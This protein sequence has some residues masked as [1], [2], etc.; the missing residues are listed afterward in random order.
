M[1]DNPQGDDTFADLFSKLPSPRTSQPAQEPESAPAAPDAPLSRRAAREAAATSEPDTAAA[2]GASE[3]AAPT[4]AAA[5][6]TPARTPDAPARTTDAPR[7]AAAAP[8]GVTVA[9]AAPQLDTLFDGAGAVNAR[10]SRHAK[11]RRKSRIAAWVIFGVILAII[12]GITAGGF[13]VWNTYED[14]IRAFMGWEEPKDY[15]AGLATGEALVTIVSGD[16]GSTISQTLY[17][18]GV[19]KT[20]EAFYDYLVQSAQNPPF[21]PG[22]Y[23]LQQ[24]MTSAAALTALLDPANKQEFT[25]QLPEG[26]TEAQTLDRLSASLGLPLADLQAA[27]ADPSAYGVNATSLEGWLFPATYTFDPGVT[28]QDVITTLVNRTVQSLDTAGVPVDQRQQVLITASIIEREARLPDDFSKVSRVIAN[29]LA[30]GMKL[31]MDSTAQYGYGEM[32][33][34]SASSSKEALEDDN[35]WNTYVIDGLP[36]TPISNPGDTAIDAAMHPTDGNW[37]YFVTWNMDTGETIFSDTYAEHE[38]A[39]AKWNE[40]CTANDNRGC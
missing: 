31:Q 1:P 29:R 17:E 35:A 4:S 11:D 33:D 15:E 18:A 10:D 14:K 5:A 40:W 23:A 22:V 25:A 36:A 7:A 12:G 6:A 26:L 30:D 27:T 28:A 34:G 37:L 16:T 20:P 2:P 3:P 8:T 21:Q 39:I 24:K 13:Y 38:A 9:D 32:H 19:T